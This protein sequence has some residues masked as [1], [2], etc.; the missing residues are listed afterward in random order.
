M[1]NFS[2]KIPD[3][4]VKKYNRNNYE[5][6]SVEGTIVLEAWKGFQSMRGPYGAKDSDEPSDGTARLTVAEYIVEGKVHISEEQV[7]AYNYITQHQEK[8]KEAILQ[9]LLS[10]YKN[11]RVY[12]D[13]DEEDE[14]MPAID[15]ISQFNNLIGLSTVRIIKVSKDDIAYVG[16]E[17][18]C[19][20]DDSYGLGFM[21][22]KDRVIQVGWA[23]DSFQTFVA[24]EDLE[25]NDPQFSKPFL[26]FPIDE[27]GDVGAA[28]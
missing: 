9:A 10:E 21:T 14:L 6:L 18:G 23:S 11:M 2:D 8:I 25:K 15:N 19:T 26:E 27:K 3:L 4:F 20:W 22:H 24:E 12:Y 16:Y 1:E 7:N 13:Y 5:S 28:G 17:F